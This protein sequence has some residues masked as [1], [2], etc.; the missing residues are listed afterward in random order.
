MR[1]LPHEQ[2]DVHNGLEELRELR[3]L[4]REVELLEVLIQRFEKEHIVVRLHARVCHLLAQSLKRGK[5]AAL[6]HLQHLDHLA[7]FLAAEL[8]VDGV[9]VRRLILPELELGERTWMRPLL[10][11]RLRVRLQ[12]SLY[13]SRPRHDRAL[14][15]VNLILIARPRALL[16]RAVR[17]ARRK[18]Q[19]RLPLCLPGW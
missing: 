13:L 1:V 3:E 15:H 17:L 19:Q 6:R 16:A 2:H 10:Q 12:H 4:V 14:Q 11:R 7:D 8:L 5:V 9:E 18:R